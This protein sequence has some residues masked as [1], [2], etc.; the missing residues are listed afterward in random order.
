MGGTGTQRTFNRTHRTQAWRRG[1]C[2]R[3]ICSRSK[4]W[5]R[6][7][8]SQARCKARWGKGREGLDVARMGGRRKWEDAGGRENCGCLACS[9]RVVS[10]LVLISADGIILPKGKQERGKRE[11]HMR[12]ARASLSSL[13][14]NLLLYFPFFFSPSLY[15]HIILSVSPPLPLFWVYS[16]TFLFPTPS[17]L[18]PYRFHNSSTSLR[19]RVPAKGH[20]SRGCSKREAALEPPPRDAASVRPSRSRS[21]NRSH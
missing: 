19:Y 8:Q 16:V 3:F 10:Y 2:L 15:I 20:Q 5:V 17:H 13:L 21:R 11:S 7:R 4:L 1:G 12:R 9:R 18:T 14:S 6:H